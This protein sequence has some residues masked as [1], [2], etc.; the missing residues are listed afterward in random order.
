MKRGAGLTPVRVPPGGVSG[1][2]GSLHG[3]RGPDS[4]Q[5]VQL[6]VRCIRPSSS[7]AAARQ[8]VTLIELMVSVALT[9]IVILAIVR[10]FDLLGGN[11]SESRSILELS[12]QLR[13]AANQLQTDL[14]QLTLK[15]HPPANPLTAPGYFE[16]IEG[17]R[18]DRDTDGDDV[19]DTDAAENGPDFVLANAPANFADIYTADPNVPMSPR[20]I[21]D[22]WGVMGDVDD[23]WMGTIRSRGEPFRG[24]FLGQIVESPQAEVAWWMEPVLGPG[25]TAVGATELVIVR[26]VLLIVPTLDVQAQLVAYQQAN[27]LNSPAALVKFLQENDVSVRPDFVDNGSGSLVPRIVPNTLADLSVRRNRFAHWHDGF[28]QIPL[29]AQTFPDLLNRRFLVRSRNQNNQL[30]NDDLVLSDALAMDV[31]VYDPLAPVYRPG[32]TARYVVTPVDP[33]FRL[34]VQAIT[35]GTP[36][37]YPESYGTYVDLGYNVAGNGNLISPLVSHF[38]GAPR[39]RSKCWEFRFPNGSLSLVP[40]LPRVYCTWSTMY[41]RD[42]IDQNTQGAG[43]VD[44]GTDGFDTPT[45]VPPEY[46]NTPYDPRFVV[47]DVFERETSPPYPQPLRGIEVVLRVRELSTQQVRQAS[48]V[49]DFVAP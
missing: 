42:G 47:D 48:V 7:P 27:P 37:S 5:G 2:R 29:P 16:I 8:G 31:R 12:A 41:E 14:D 13:T 35:P 1:S 43:P 4:E 15:P 19:V 3:S 44:E 30:L 20:L 38:S 26:R 9:L 34:A 11:V 10:V 22:L 36:N 17:K 46:S 6:V 21:K 33:G 24:R 32:N 18:S 39:R 45:P 49:G 28:L 25:G 23:V 40:V